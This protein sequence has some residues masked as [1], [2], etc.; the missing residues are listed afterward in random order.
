[1]RARGSSV[2]VRLLINGLVFIGVVV[3][4]RD[5]GPADAPKPLQ[6]PKEQSLI[7]HVRGKGDQ[8]YVCQGAG[9]AYAWK[10]KGP[11]AKLYSESGELAGRHFAG[12]TWEA[13]DGSRVIAQVAANVP[14]PEPGSIP[15]LLLT[16]KAHE[17]SGI[18][19]KVQSIQRLDTKG[20]VAPS[21]G[22]S[23]ANEN[24]QMA[25]PYEADYYFYGSSR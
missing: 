14:S 16:A 3:A 4:Q 10:L 9:G 20:G 12:P 15:W 25:V 21:S 6:P 7:M 8:V 1:M 22:C 11:D 19:A 2:A 17:Q 23:A 13:N 5:S 24:Q 18:M